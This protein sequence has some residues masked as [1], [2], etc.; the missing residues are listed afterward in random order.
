MKL[1]VPA[2]RAPGPAANRDGVADHTSELLDAIDALLAES[3]AEAPAREAQKRRL[4]S[5]ALHPSAGL[6]KSHGA[7]RPVPPEAA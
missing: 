5:M 1:T 2:I 3:M 7:G 4:A 6:V